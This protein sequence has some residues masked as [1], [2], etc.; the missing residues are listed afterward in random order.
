M[1]L[2]CSTITLGEPVKLQDVAACVALIP[3]NIR[4]P[5]MKDIAEFCRDHGVDPDTLEQS[6][7]HS[8]QPCVYTWSDEG[9]ITRDELVHDPEKY[10]S[11]IKSDTVWNLGD[12]SHDLAHLG[13]KYIKLAE[14]EETIERLPGKE[15]SLATVDD[16]KIERMRSL[17]VNL[18]EEN[19]DIEGMSKDIVQLSYDEW[20]HKK[21]WDLTAEEMMKEKHPFKDLDVKE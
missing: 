15:K 10:L 19:W 20:K 7:F 12:M 8:R 17:A 9:G 16:S 6:M 5:A 1:T 4:S 18:R 11:N 13:G 14:E 2:Q 21:A 3:K